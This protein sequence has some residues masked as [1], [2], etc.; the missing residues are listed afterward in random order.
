M[1]LSPQDLYSQLM[2]L[3]TAVSLWIW[4]NLEKAWESLWQSNLQNE[5]EKLAA[6]IEAW[7]DF[8]AGKLSLQ[9]EIW[10]QSYLDFQQSLTS[11]LASLLPLH[12]TQMKSKSEV[13]LQLPTRD[14]QGGRRQWRT[15]VW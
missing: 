9:Q 7:I 5:W 2:V 1:S 3:W 11:M 15:V 4:D 6:W 8:W 10:T 14:I 13:N 12:L